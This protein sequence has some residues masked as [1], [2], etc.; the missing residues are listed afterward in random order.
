[1][2]AQKPLSIGETL[3][4]LLR[5]E[6]LNQTEAALK[7][8]VT[9]QY[10]NSVINDK[11]PLTTELQW[12]L[13][14]VLKRGLDYWEDI[15]KQYDKFLATPDGRRQ[16]LQAK[17]EELAIH[18]DLQGQRT[19][20]NYEIETA[21]N[22]GVI[23]FLSG[24][25]ER[26]TPAFDK[27]RLRSTTYQLSVGEQAEL[28]DTSGKSRVVRTFPYLELGR[29]E[30]ARL[31]T[32][33]AV[34]IGGRLRA[35]IQGLADPLPWKLVQWMGRLIVEPWNEAPVTF[36]LINHGPETVR[37]IHGQPCLEISF[38]YL[39]A[40]PMRPAAPSEAEEATL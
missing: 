2:T 33:E 10:L 4:Q 7:I 40:E 21:V 23:A 15:S 12:K 30:V 17:E 5:K 11:L 19:L 20:V 8:G 37:L 24:S 35:H 26:E 25:G 39:A 32:L 13:Q 38:E 9:R 27:R 6:G 28:F 31:A 22:S 29:G 1:M 14:P 16:Q 3:E 18:W 34:K 36:G